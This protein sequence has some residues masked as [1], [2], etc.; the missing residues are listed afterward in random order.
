MN[1]PFEAINAA[2]MSILPDLAAELFPAGRRVRN[3]FVVGDINGSP[4]ESLKVNL[5]TGKWK[6]FGGVPGGPDPISLFAHASHNRDR[7]AAARALGARLGVYMNGSAGKHEPTPKRKP[8]DDWQP[9]VPP[10]IDAPK[11]TAAQ[12]QCN[13]LAEYHGLD[14][15]LLHYV[16]RIETKGAKLPLPLTYG[17]WKGKI[18]WHQKGP[19]NPRPLYGLNRLLDRPD[20]DV[21]LHEGEWKADVCQELW[22]AFIHLSIAGG[23]KAVAYNDLSP[24]ATRRVIYSPDNDETGADAA[25]AIVSRLPQTRVIRVD[26]LPPTECAA[27]V[28]HT[29]PEAWLRDRLREPEPQLKP[30]LRKLLTPAD[31]KDE[32]PRPYV[33]KGLIAE[34]DHVCLIGQPGSG[35]SVLAPHIAYAVAQ[36]RQV[37]GRRVKAG[38]ILYIAAEDPHGM[39]GRVRALLKRY[40][41]APNFH[42]FPTS[43]DLTNP[44]DVQEIRQHVENIRPVLIII[45]TIARAFPGLKENDDMGPPVAMARGLASI[46]GSAVMTIHH[47]TKDGG[48]TPRGHGA[49]NGDVDTILLIEGAR[50]EVRTV[51]LGKNRNGPSDV[52]FTFRIEVE[53]MGVDEDGDPITWP[54]AVEGGSKPEKPGKPL[55]VAQEGWFRDICNMFNEPDATAEKVP[56]PTMKPV[57]TLARAQVRAGLRVRNRFTADAHAALTD[58]DRR[59]FTDALNA[60]RDN[61]KIGMANDLIWLM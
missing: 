38:A 28:Q 31:I 3:N 5:D 30:G 25:A 4:G 57:L 46:C 42:L 33:V 11:P 50:A 54:I 41:N 13:H 56:I 20:A 23:G 26:D 18:G 44:V 43:V 17:S 37:L 48:T 55:S 36:G 49:L 7:V 27:D 29:D 22:P 51:K 16:T 45:E 10:P 14:G 19:G 40:G 59:K 8:A 35:K 47:P 2:A 34:G 21:M 6:D 52:T 15:R 58:N 39:R 60:L 12:L 24:V 9:M 61:G 32:Q 1:I 53:D